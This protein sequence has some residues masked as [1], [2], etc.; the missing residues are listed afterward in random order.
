[1]RDGVTASPCSRSA[2]DAPAMIK[3]NPQDGR[4]MISRS[5]IS[6]GE[7]QRHEDGTAPRK[8]RWIFTDTQEQTQ[9]DF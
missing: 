9:G 4:F 7:R 1:M 6:G 8:R 3:L 5:T 2:I